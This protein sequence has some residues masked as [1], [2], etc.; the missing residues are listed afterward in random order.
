MNFVEQRAADKRAQV[1]RAE[2]IAE[3]RLRALAVQRTAREKAHFVSR[4][5]RRFDE[6]SSGSPGAAEDRDPHPQTIS[7][8][9]TS[10]TQIQSQVSER[11]R[12]WPETHALPKSV[13]LLRGQGKRP[14][15]P[16]IFSPLAPPV[17]TTLS[18]LTNG[19]T[20]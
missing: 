18:A 15:R 2:R 10:A 6:E 1:L 12:R 9:R 16:T 5:Q 11:A 7:M 4:A 14:R 13:T 20:R 19:V 17:G 8:A 3:H